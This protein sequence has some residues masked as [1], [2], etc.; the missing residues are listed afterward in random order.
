MKQ[1]HR[2]YYAA[3][4]ADD[5][6]QRELVRVYGKHRAGDARYKL[7]HEDAR[8][9]AAGKRKRK[10]DERLRRCMIRPKPKPKK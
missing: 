2:L 9:T 4:R 7:R 1:C 5:V 3:L 10:A 6:F 8:I